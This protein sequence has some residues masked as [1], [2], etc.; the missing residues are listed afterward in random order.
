[1]S[2]T[3]LEQ[4]KELTATLSPVEKVQLIEW[5]GAAVVQEL[6]NQS[7]DHQANGGTGADAGPPPAATDALPWEERPWTEE[8]IRA[9]VK[10]DPKTGAEI[11]AMIESGEIDTSEWAALNLPDSVEWVRQQRRQLRPG[12]RWDE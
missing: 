3:V 8:E 9:L 2:A 1:M 5:L 7:S 10:P 4:V 6:T 11:A 12:V